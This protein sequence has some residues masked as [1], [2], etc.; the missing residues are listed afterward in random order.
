MKRDTTE[1]S[2]V[3]WLPGL[4]ENISES[5]VNRQA[6]PLIDGPFHHKNRLFLRMIDKCLL[7]L[8]N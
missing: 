2:C 8:L 7:D 6:S 3:T 1:G 4:F 5:M